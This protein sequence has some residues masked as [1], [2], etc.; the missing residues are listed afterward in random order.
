MKPLSSLLLLTSFA[1][2][3]CGAPA[4]VATPIA[5]VPAS[6]PVAAAPQPAS[7]AAAVTLTEAPRNWQ[8]LD[9]TQDGIP[10]IGSER[11][12]K[13]LLAG[14]APKQTVLV[15]IIDDGID[16][17]HVDLRANL[18]TNAKE[19]AGNKKDDDHNGYVDDIHGWNFLGGKDGEDVHFDTFEITRQY[20]ACHDKA[21][22]SGQPTITDTAKCAQIDTDY[23]K[24]RTEISGQFQQLQQ[25]HAVM[26]QIIPMLKQ[27]AMTD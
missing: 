27:A 23:E 3:A 16:T 13:E 8:L 7:H 26:E 5:P 1:L 24:Q 18:W 20:A 10:G 9:E 11:A 12:M 19:I 17:A 6:A 2:A 25:I 15:A 22:A 14:Q 4:T 21:A